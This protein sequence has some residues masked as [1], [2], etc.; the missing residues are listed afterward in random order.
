MS[1]HNHIES[2]G[3][4]EKMENTNLRATA[5]ALAQLPPDVQKI[6]LYIAQG[7]KLAR[8]TESEDSRDGEQE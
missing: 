3:G 7:I 1:Y 8:I 4:E 6:V 2:N 5:T